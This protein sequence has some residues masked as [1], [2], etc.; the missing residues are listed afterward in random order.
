M[1][2]LPRW[3][4]RERLHP[5]ERQ[6]FDLMCEVEQAGADPLLTRAVCGLQEALHELVDWF[7]AGQPGNDFENGNRPLT[8]EDEAIIQN[9][10]EKLKPYFAMEPYGSAASGIETEGQDRGT[11]LGAEHESPVPKADAQGPSQ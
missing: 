9:S 5:L 4:D 11:G 10:W 1:A 3:T 8:L 2:D 7:D 6:I